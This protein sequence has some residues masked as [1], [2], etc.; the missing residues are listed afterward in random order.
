MT[1]RDRSIGSSILIMYLKAI[2][3]INDL[4]QLLTACR[5]V[6]LAYTGSVLIEKLA[7]L[8]QASVEFIVPG[9]DCSTKF[10]FKNHDNRSASG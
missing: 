8:K 2:H 3:C 9:A 7:S 1:S 10:P 5:I 4:L 6:I